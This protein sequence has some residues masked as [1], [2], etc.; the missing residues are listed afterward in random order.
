MTAKSRCSGVG[1]PRRNPWTTCGEERVEGREGE[2]E[3]ERER[4]EREGGRERERGGGG[5]GDECMSQ[6]EGG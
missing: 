2:K 4:G 1:K 6:T 3:R 5:E